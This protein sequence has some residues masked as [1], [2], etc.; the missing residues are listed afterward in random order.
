MTNDLRTLIDTKLNSIKT[1]YGI[2][3]IGYRR[4]SDQKMYPHV[5][6]N[7]LTRDPLDMGRHDFLIEIDVWGKEE[8]VVFNIIDAI[9]LMFQFSNDPTENI[10]PTFFDVRSG[11]VE[12]PDKTLVHGI[13]RVDCQLY[14]TGVTDNGILNPERS[15]NGD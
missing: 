15:N 7:I 10:L 2:K 1:A 12:D 11:T 3:D 4:A 14:E 5:V 6:W 9:V 13:V 8:A